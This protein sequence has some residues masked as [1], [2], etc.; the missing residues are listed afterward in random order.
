MK[1]T[2]K[3][4]LGALIFLALWGCRKNETP[5]INESKTAQSSG[6][7]YEDLYDQHIRAGAFGILELASDAGFVAMV[8]NACDEQFD[9][10]DNV[11]FKRISELASENQIDLKTEMES[12]LQNVGKTDL[13]PLVDGVINGF[14]YY[15]TKIYLQVYIPFIENYNA[16]RSPW[17]SLNF[18]DDARLES[19]RLQ[20]GTV[21]DS[22][23]DETFAQAN[24]V[25]VISGNETVDINGELPMHLKDNFNKTA[26][27]TQVRISDKKENWA[28]G[29]ADISYVARHARIS[30]CT[31]DALFDP[32]KWIVKISNNQ[33]NNWV[34]V[35]NSLASFALPIANSDLWNT[36]ENIVIL[37]YERDLRQKDRK[38]TKP[39]QYLNYP[40]C[41]NSY[42]ME[43]ISKETM[44][45]VTLLFRENYH[46][47]NS[48]GIENTYP[49][50]NS[51]SN[52]LFGGGFKIKAQ[53]W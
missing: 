26:R 41:Q 29:K 17:I 38:T 15:E 51:P 33:L 40:W 9:G 16:D 10:D 5:Q 22:E 42:E 7:Y 6:E 2:T 36:F 53:N 32:Q 21:A 48:I 34:S 27:I 35:N 28:N 46:D 37:Y 12:C 24:P 3:L 52:K 11:L 50:G 31:S 8:K 18:N 39:L 44:Y 13:V 19:Y 49:E 23:I 4:M 25:W 14:D 30:N 1:N 20:N 45:G 47:P 43:Y